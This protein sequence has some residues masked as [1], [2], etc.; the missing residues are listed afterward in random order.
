M[1]PP[2]AAAE[3]AAPRPPLLSRRPLRVLATLMMHDTLVV[4]LSSSSGWIESSLAMSARGEKWRLANNPFAP[5]MI[6]FLL[7]L[8]LLDGRG[9]G[10]PRRTT[11]LRPFK[12]RRHTKSAVVLFIYH[13]YYN[14]V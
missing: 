14:P 2:L 5:P 10:K 9:G 6:R 13:Y 11:S 7:L 3:C 1:K 8:L 4:L 12:T